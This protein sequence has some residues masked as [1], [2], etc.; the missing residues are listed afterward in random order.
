M[1]IISFLYLHRKAKFTLH[2]NR[3]SVFFWGGG[4]EEEEEEIGFS[5]GKILNCG[6]FYNIE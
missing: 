6:K 5:D 2:S 1:D 3:W 4:E